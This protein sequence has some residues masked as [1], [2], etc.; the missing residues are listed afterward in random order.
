MSNKATDQG[1]V[2]AS[3]SQLRPGTGCLFKLLSL[4]FSSMILTWD[5][6]L[7]KL[8]NLGLLVRAAT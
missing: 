3:R 1:E 7:L 2:A 4:D 6:C 8:M 5:F